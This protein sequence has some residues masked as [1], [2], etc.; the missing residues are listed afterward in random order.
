MPTKKTPKNSSRFAQWAFFDLF[1]LFAVLF[2]YK[3]AI[4][5]TGIGAVMVL[6][7]LLVLANAPGIWEDYTGRYKPSKSAWLNRLNEPKLAYYNLNRF[8]LC[9]LI[10][11]TG[12]AA[13]FF[14]FLIG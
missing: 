11:L 10:L 8:V 6:G 9:P 13:I 1:V 12:L 7:S 4:G 14:G 2:V 5:M 3:P